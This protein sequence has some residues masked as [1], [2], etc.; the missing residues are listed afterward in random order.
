MTSYIGV[1]GTASIP[2]I[3]VYTG[4]A[5]QT[6]YGMTLLAKETY[7][8]TSTFSISNVFTSAYRNYRIVI[9]NSAGAVT[10]ALYLRF[11]QNTTDYTTAGYQN[12]FLQASGASVSASRSGA[13]NYFDLGTNSS[14]SDKSA[15]VI[16][17]LNPQIATYTHGHLHEFSGVSG[18]GPVI[19]LVYNWI[20]NTQV[21]D[22][23]TILSAGG[24]NI[25]GNVTV[26]GYRN[27]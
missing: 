27:A 15:M 17:V 1:T 13:I 21:F 14:G 20:F 24:T 8:A 2:Q 18:A 22:G 16:D 6:P 7:S 3:E 9:D 5:W 10:Q 25:S 4:S 11:R 12:Q 26:Y 23:F 19:N